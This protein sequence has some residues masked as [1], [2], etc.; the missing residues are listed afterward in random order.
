MNLTRT[1][2]AAMTLL[3]LAACNSK[4]ETSVPAGDAAQSAASAPVAAA[5]AAPQGLVEGQNYTVLAN[6]I[7]QQ[8][9]GKVEVLEFF[10][11]FC[12][13]CAHLEPVLSEHVKTFKNDTYLRTEHVV[14]GD[15][16]KPLARLLAAVDMA[17]GKSK[18]NSVI[19]NAIVDQKINLADPTVL[20]DWLAKQTTFDGSKVLAAYDTPESQSRADQM[21]QLTNTYQI[22]S[23]PT[24]IVGG[25][26]QVK[27][28]S[29]SEGM[30]TIDLL[31]DKVREEQKL[32]A[33]K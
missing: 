16:M 19:F 12:P 1:T 26:Y 7:P 11:Y 10:G 6:P 28:S 14:W 13:H 9:A 29:W 33:A 15:E 4:V 5:S 17:G 24:V 25:K 18:A 8:Q 30:H 20:K 3:A 2:L 22:S 31:V 23:T 27:F 32:P 21:E